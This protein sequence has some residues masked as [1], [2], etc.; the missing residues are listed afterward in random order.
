MKDIIE[1]DFNNPDIYKEKVWGNTSE[2][3]NFVNKK[4]DE[5]EGKTIGEIFLVS[6]HPDGPSRF[7]NGRLLR[8]DIHDEESVFGKTVGPKGE[9]PLLLKV[10]SAQKF[11]SVQTHYKNKTEAWHMLSEGE[12]LYGLTEAGEKILQTV[13][14][15]E[16]LANIMET[17][18]TSEELSKYFNYVKFKAGETYLIHAGIVHSLLRG[19]VLEPQKNSN[20]TIRGGDWGR[21][22]SKRPLQIEDFFASIYPYAIKPKA[23]KPK[24]KTYRT[25]KEAP[26]NSKHACLVATSDFAL[27]K[28]ILKN[29]KRMLETFTDRFFIVIVTRGNINL[30]NGVVNKRV[31]KGQIFILGA[32][33]NEWVFSGRGEIMLVYVPHIKM[34]IIT[35]LKNSNYSYK[36]IAA[37]GGPTLK[38]NDVY[39]QMKELGLI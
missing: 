25:D 13:E 6:T 8:E 34:G 39:I 27:D 5:F 1:I 3:V 7:N 36:E 18:K 2:V 15:R 14:G 16:A 21:N 32:T 20:L 37:I 29:G 33:S 9:F 26:I 31:N 12:M 23:I 24:Y 35:P 17:A 22:D 11:L 38:E 19:T 30:T 10:L 4:V 28:I